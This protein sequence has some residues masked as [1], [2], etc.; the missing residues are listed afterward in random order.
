[1]KPFDD[2][3][4]EELEEPHQELI[5]LLHQA[6][7]QTH[8]DTAAAQQQVLQRVGKQLAKLEDAITFSDIDETQLEPLPMEQAQLRE[9]EMR[10]GKPNRSKRAIRFIDMLAA[11]LTVGL[12]LS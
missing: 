11:V 6:Y 8:V 5:S 3:L 1:M 4:P 9:I 12:L 7:H 10:G 2:T